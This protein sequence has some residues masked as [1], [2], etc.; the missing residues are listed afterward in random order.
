[1]VN[2]T[3][4]LTSSLPKLLLCL[5]VLVVNATIISHLSLIAC[6]SVSMITAPNSRHTFPLKGPLYGQYTCTHT[7]LC[8]QIANLLI[9]LINNE[10]CHANIELRKENHDKSH[11]TLIKLLCYVTLMIYYLKYVTTSHVKLMKQFV[12]CH[13]KSC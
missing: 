12:S 11:I 7:D 5:V 4:A 13:V 3:C 6:L 2:Q 1:M 10:T 8:R 9:L